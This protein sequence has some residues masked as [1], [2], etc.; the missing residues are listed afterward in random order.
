MATSVT[1]QVANERCGRCLEVLTPGPKRRSITSHFLYCDPCADLVSYRNVMVHQHGWGEACSTCHD[2]A[3]TV[4]FACKDVEA[5]F[6]GLMEPLHGHSFC[7]D[8]TNILDDRRY[9]DELNDRNLLFCPLCKGLVLCVREAVPEI[10]VLVDDDMEQK[11]A[12]IVDVR[13]TENIQAQVQVQFPNTLETDW[14]SLHELQGG[15]LAT[16][17]LLLIQAKYGGGGPNNGENVGR[18]VE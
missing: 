6:A 9:E 8:C 15:R 11:P 5:G 14:V 10:V 2:T 12:E 18:Q 1:V 13:V 7:V 4:Y 17:A 16:Q 3:A